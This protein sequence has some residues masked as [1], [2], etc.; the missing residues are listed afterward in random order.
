MFFL[1]VFVAV[2]DRKYLPRKTPVLAALGLTLFFLTLSTIF[3][4]NPFRSFW[5]NYERME[6]LI[7]H[8]HLFAY[9]IILTSVLRIKRDWKILFGTMIGVS[10]LVTIYGFLQFFGRTAIHQGDTRVDATFGNSAYLAV[11]L[12]FHL[13]L[14]ALFLFWSKKLWLRISLGFLFLLEFFVMLLTATRGA[15]LGFFGGLFLFG[16][17]M[18]VFSKNK[19]LRY[20][21]ALVVV[22]IVVLTSLFLFFKGSSFVKQNYVLARLASISFSDTTV[23]S[24]FTIWGM[25]WRGFQEHPLLGWGPENYNL[26]FNNYYEPILYKQEPWFDRSHNV[27]F[28]WLTTT[29]L[30]GALSYLG[31]FMTTLYMIWTGYKRKIFSLTESTLVVSVLAAYT[32]HNLF[33]FDNLTSYFMFFSILGY[34]H[35]SYS[36]KPKDEDNRQKHKMSVKKEIGG[37]GYFL[38]TFVFLL[39]I[40]SL[41]FVNVKPMMA[42]NSLLR[43]L[44]VSRGNNPVGVVL[45]EYQK[46]FDYKTFGTTEAR[47]QLSG[48]VN[49]I[50]SNPNISQSDKDKVITKA[51]EQM[52]I[53]VAKAPEDSRY[54]LFL[55]F[56]YTRAG[57]YEKALDALNNALKFSPKKQQ[58]MFAISDI[59]LSAGDNQKALEI[60]QN[61]YDLDK[62]YRIAGTNLA[63]IA[64]TVDL[65]YAEKLLSEME[66]IFGPKIRLDRKLINGYARISDYGKVKDIWLN[67]IKE[68]PLNAQ[69]RINLAATYLQLEE[70]TEAIEQLEKAKEISPESVEQLDYFISEILAGRNP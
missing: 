29:G 44:S 2:F 16:I 12:I 41:Y 68:E 33:V 51:I 35:S 56:L 63:M 10:S 28:D 24:R 57:Q 59:Y 54:S 13:F 36:E 34:V 62:S 53:Q 38:I 58:I 60:L 25:S 26:V 42:A 17:L 64:L 22:L 23:E 14:I 20:S 66:T 70:R 47:E 11:F 43:A 27:M 21:F 40:F 15:I 7:G 61:A 4:E 65:D 19:K 5:S 31:I 39:T 69:Y 52:E 46:V 49:T 55:G 9:F 1:W 6:G 3:G 30:F 67:S 50:F 8:L 45:N 48:Y 18:L 32:F 37:L